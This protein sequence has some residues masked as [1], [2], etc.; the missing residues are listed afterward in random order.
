MFPIPNP[1]NGLIL[2]PVHQ[3]TISQESIGWFHSVVV[4]TFGSDPN[5]P[6][7]NPG[8]T[9]LSCFAFQIISVT[10]HCLVLR[11]AVVIEIGIS[12][13]LSRHGMEL[14]PSTVKRRVVVHLSWLSYLFPRIHEYNSQLELLLRSSYP[15][16]NNSCT[17]LL[18]VPRCKMY[19]RGPSMV[20]TGWKNNSSLTHF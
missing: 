20:S 10:I 1:H 4:I 13:S 17:F 2:I 19:L 9:S 12:N 5:N 11:N 15:T 7:S 6:G 8:G 3:V 14:P 18:V 16:R